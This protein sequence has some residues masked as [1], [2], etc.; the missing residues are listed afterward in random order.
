M[1][2]TMADQARRPSGALHTE[3]LHGWGNTA[4]S[5]AEVADPTAVEQLAELV[6]TAGPRGVIARGLGRSYGD[7]A[8]NAGGRVV[9]TTSLDKILSV[10]VARGRVVAQSGVSLHQ[11]MS[12]MLPLGWFVPVTPG[13][14]YVTVGGA[15]GAD[16]HGKNHHSA[17]S[18]C[19]HVESLEL[20]GADGQVRTVTPENDPELFWA[21]AGGMGLT[22]IVVSAAIQFKKVETSRIKADI[23]RAPDLDG[24]MADLADTDHK[25]PY[26]VAWIDCLAQGRCL[27]RSV[28]TC[29][30]FAK[31]DEL[32]PKAR[33]EPRKFAPLSLGTVPPVPVSGLLNK[34]TGRAFNE[35]WFRKAPVRKEGVIQGVGAFFHP[36]DGIMQWNRVYGPAG[37]LQWQFVVPFGA[38]D[39][40]RHIVERISAHGA[41]AA[42]TVLKRFG[43]GNSGYLSFPEAGW[44]LAL[45][46]PTRVHGLAELLDGLDEKVLEAG[47]RLYLAK[48]SR[49][50]PELLDA[51]YPRLEAFRKLRA[52]I[53]PD[54]VF[55]SDQARR[56]NL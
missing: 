12:T 37:F 23:W 32:P 22:G 16:I 2:V 8:Q 24:V 6:T 50:R 9:R 53:D 14:R 19:Q 4:P 48:D 46:F 40:L 33:R 27:G 30:D 20:L 5:V 26:T 41:P 45:D 18:F 54:Q 52:E 10:D 42:L 11:L 39:T 1:G 49:M 28:L 3:T 29:G 35:M 44:T 47:G 7:P 56:L 13:T 21:T 36:L 43:A 15:I 25:Y 55:M 31:L 34:A 17:G 38:E 51:M